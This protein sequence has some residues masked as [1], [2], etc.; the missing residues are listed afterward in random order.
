MVVI[1]KFFP[2]TIPDNEELYFQYLIGVI[3]SVD[4][5]CYLQITKLSDSYHFRLSP[6]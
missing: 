1:K 3:E 5:L 2:D 4:E 6:S